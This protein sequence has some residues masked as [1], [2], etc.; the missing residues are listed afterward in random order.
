[1]PSASFWLH[2]CVRDGGLGDCAL[3]QPSLI[4]L[5]F[6]HRKF[7]GPTMVEPDPNFWWNWWP[8]AF[9]AVGTVGAV[10]VAL[11]SEPIRR[12][13]S[14]TPN[15]QISQTN[16]A[17][18]GTCANTST[19]ELVNGQFQ[20]RI[21]FSRW[22]HI[23]VVNTRREL[24]A[25]TQV[26]LW[27]IELAVF[28]ANVAGNWRSA[29]IGEIPMSWKDQAVKLPAL[30]IGHPDVADLVSLTKGGEGVPHR[31]QLS[32]ALFKYPPTLEWTAACNVRGK[33]S[34]EEC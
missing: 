29:W 20:Q 13:L 25:A 18:E 34:G 11:F 30:T 26:R 17:Q 21:T 24:V 7:R 2:P 19:Y 3:G 15:L 4:W 22:Y 14:I 9:T 28:D 32:A 23:D 16:N 12:L 8:S 31:L 33:A 27:M 10:I 1:M 6:S 5:A